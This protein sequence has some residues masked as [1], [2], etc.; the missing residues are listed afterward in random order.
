M[1]ISCLATD[2]DGTLAHDGIV[3]DPTADALV[4]FRRSGRKLLL[5]TGRELPDLVRVL[6]RIDLFDRVVAENGALLFDPATKK[7]TPLG[8]EPS[9]QLV[10]TLR[11]KG[12]NPL[13]VG[14]SIIATWEPNEKLVLDAIREHGL[15][16]Q[17]VFNKGAVMV[18]PPGV[19][20]AS[21]LKAA[22]ED[23]GL[24]AHNVVSVGDAENDHAFLQASGYAVAV[25]NALPTI[26]EEADLVMKAARGAGVVELIE[27]VL[28]SDVDAFHL[29]ESH[30]SVEVG[31][32]AD[33]R[34][35]VIRPHGGST[36]ICGSSGGGKSTVATA[37]LERI[38]EGGY[39]ICVF[40]PEGDYAEFRGGV[41][42]GDAK[43]PP[44]LAEVVKQLEGPDD[45]FVINM[46]SVPFEDRP[47]LLSDFIS[48]IANLR[49]KIGRPHWVLMDEAHHLLPAERDL[50]ATASLES[51]P[52]VIIL[53]V[54]PATL[55]V[56]ALRRVDDVFAVGDKASEAVEAFAR[57]LS[58][59][60]PELPC[61][62]PG[63]G[64]A[65]FWRR[66]AGDRAHIIKPHTPAEKAERHIR[67]YAEGALGEDKSFYFRG[68][69][70]ALN[71]RAQNLT[72][73]MQMADGVD[74]DT[75]IHHL[76]AH[77]YSRW[78]RD[79][80]KDEDLANELVQIEGEPAGDPQATRREVREAIER[81][82]T[83]PAS[84]R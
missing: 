16:L 33:G 14:R 68:P 8:P 64:E 60:A 71:L 15:E 54:D 19:N 56:D 24:S 31:L 62:P 11:K 39:Q 58:I 10:E 75:W 80:I 12:V 52:P 65:L 76:R 3:D 23:L 7:E 17:I 83:A 36:L 40:D 74:D 27:A 79:A 9:P 20:K 53:T 4:A 37:L 21:G 66:S 67:K 32:D 72:I 47:A 69:S 2:Y 57:A 13:S 73:F 77:D 38:V 41:V 45:S 6:P 35:I 42:F 50:S 26:K 43:S 84:A 81:K 48:A 51:L 78:V 1:Y 55:A 46:L 34:P 18:L 22:L 61:A 25:A 63:K 28:K 29:R 49:A 70:N 59:S 5:V 30:N 44:Q 82:Y